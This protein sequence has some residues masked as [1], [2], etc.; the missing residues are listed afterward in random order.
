MDLPQRIQEDQEI[1]AAVERR[2]QRQPLHIDAE[3]VIRRVS[4][5]A[6][7]PQLGSLGQ[8]DAQA[9]ADTEDDAEADQ[10]L[11]QQDAGDMPLAHAQHVVEPQLPLAAA[12]Q[13]GIGVKQKDQRE[14]RD[15]P[16]SQDQHG[17]QRAA[18][19]HPSDLLGIPQRD[20]DVP[21]HRH[22]GA[23]H[24]I[25]Q[26]QPSVLPHAHPGQPPVQSPFHALPPVI[27]TVSVSVIFW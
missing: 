12:D 27:S 16:R 26:I 5:D 6:H 20:Q 21:D 18:A 15:D 3:A 1:D 4:H 10:R 8:Q 19:V 7:Q 17:R 2:A 24:E 25:R 22:H 13:E 23:G 14:K 11:P 9:G